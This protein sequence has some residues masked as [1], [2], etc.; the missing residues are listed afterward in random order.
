ML[1][2]QRDH[3]LPL[4]VIR[5]HLDAHDAGQ[6]PPPIDSGVPAVPTVTLARHGLPSR[7]TF[8][9]DSG[10]RVSRRELLKIV[11]LTEEQLVE[12]EGFGLLAG[13]PGTGDFDGDDLVVA[14]AARD[15]ADF[16]LEPRHLR[17]FRTA[18]DREVSLVQQVVAPVAKGRDASSRARAQEQAAEMAALAVRLHAGLVR[19]GLRRP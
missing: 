4:K 1:R 13:R 18:A 11:G 6:E 16:G 15:L 7:D 10:Q 17:A 14:R 12:L 5:E 3:Y 8:A 2:L 9:H 19:Q